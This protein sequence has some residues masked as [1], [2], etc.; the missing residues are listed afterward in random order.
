MPI[1]PTNYTVRATTL[2][3]GDTDPGWFSIDSGTGSEWLNAGTGTA[4]TNLSNAIYRWGGE[5]SY[6]VNSN[7]SNLCINGEAYPKKIAAEVKRKQLLDSQ[8]EIQL[9]NAPEHIKLFD[10]NDVNS[11]EFLK[12]ERDV[13]KHSARK[14]Q[15]YVYDV[16]EVPEKPMNADEEFYQDSIEARGLKKTPMGFYIEDPRVKYN[17]RFKKIVQLRKP[18]AFITPRMMTE[19][20]ITPQ[21]AVARALLRRYVGEK[22]YKRYRRFGYIMMSAHGFTWKVPGERG[23]VYYV[24]Q[25][26]KNRELNKYCVH[27]Q[28]SKIPPTDACVMR[29]ALINSG[30]EN[31]KK[32]S[33]CFQSSIDLSVSSPI[34]K[35]EQRQLTTMEAMKLVKEQYGA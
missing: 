8:P 21:E 28:D 30:I 34:V 26:H 24:I 12:I 23:T 27:F 33:N 16:Y 1:A 14:P 11:Q 15:G 25:Y 19:K 18:P 29:M 6:L 35:T 13:I 9:F 5:G 20:I 2:T 4:A 10:P 3:D 17:F 22:E 31:L 32:H 7:I